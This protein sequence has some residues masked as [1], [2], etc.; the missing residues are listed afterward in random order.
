MKQ[1]DDPTRTHVLD[2]MICDVY[3]VVDRHLADR[4]GGIEDVEEAIADVVSVLPPRGHVFHK[5]GIWERT[6][7]SKE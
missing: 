7:R 3:K 4:S 5:L 6:Y 2:C 1:P